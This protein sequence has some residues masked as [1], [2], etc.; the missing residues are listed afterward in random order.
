MNYVYVP[1]SKSCVRR[2]LRHI[3]DDQFFMT[4]RLP[5]QKRAIISY[6]DNHL[7]P[8]KS[9]CHLH[10]LVHVDQFN[11]WW[12]PWL[13][14][15]FAAL[16]PLPVFFSGRWFIE[17]NAYLLDILNDQETVDSA[18]ERLWKHYFMPWPK[19]LMRKWFTKKLKQSQKTPSATAR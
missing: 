5:F 14:P 7:N 19:P 1:S 3:I 4:Y 12:G 13:I 17:R 8:E 2:L 15:L 11:H 9:T 16:L 6:P 18:T 10:E